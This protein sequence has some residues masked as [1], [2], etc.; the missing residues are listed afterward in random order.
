MRTTL[1]LTFLLASSVVMAGRIS[2]YYTGLNN[3]V[4]KDAANDIEKRD[5]QRR[6][7][8][9]NQGMDD[10]FDDLTGFTWN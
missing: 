5:T 6:D 8:T 3:D 2:T 4:E 7:I 1:L 10:I 9:R